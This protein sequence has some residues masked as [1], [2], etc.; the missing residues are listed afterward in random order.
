MITIP[1]VGEV[2]LLDAATGK[3]AATA[4][5]LRLYTAIS[6][7]LGSGSVAGQLTEAVGGGYAAQALTAANWTTTPA[8]PTSS[9][10]PAKTFTF[11][12]ALTGNPAIL[13]YY[14]TRADGTLI[15]AEALPTPFT[16]TTAGD[17]LI[18]TPQLTLGSL[19]ND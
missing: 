6:P 15:G 9:A 8:T 19:V 5:T 1:N 12:G 11:T 14:I 4:W 18:V 2:A 7:T 16:P 3:T 13:G 17:S 10:Q